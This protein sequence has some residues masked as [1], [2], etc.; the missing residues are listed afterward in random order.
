MLKDGLINTMESKKLMIYKLCFYIVWSLFLFIILQKGYTIIA[1]DT[2]KELREMNMPAF[3]HHLAYGKNL[4]ARSA[5]K[6]AIPAPTSMYGFFVPLILAPFVRLFSFTTLNTLQIC[7]LVTLLIE[8]AGALIFYRLLRRKT[9]RLLL[10]AIGMLLFYSCYWRYSAFGGAFPDQW[11]LTLSILLADILYRDKQKNRLRPALYILILI[12]LFYIKQYFALTA[13][14]L[15]V[16]LFIYSKKDTVKFL[17]YGIVFGILSVL[18]VHLI[19]PLYFSEVLPIAQ[20]QVLTGDPGYSLRQ[21]VVLNK[22]YGGLAVLGFLHILIEIYMMI[23]K[24]TVKR[25]ISYAFCQLIFLLLPVILISENQGTN[26]TYY[27]QLWYPYVILYCASS[28]PAITAYIK[29]IPHKNIRMLC[30][31]LQYALVLLP[32]FKMLPMFRCTLM[33]QEEEAAW[34]RAYDILE[35][36]SEGGLLVSMLLSNYCLENNIAT[37]NYGQAEY[38]TQE[39]LQN[40]KNNKLWRNIFLFD[41]TEEIL[42]KNISYHIQIQENIAEQKYSCIAITYTWEYWLSEEYLSDAGYHILTTES[43]PAGDQRWN[44]TFYVTD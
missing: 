42:Q 5:L 1:Y 40:Y 11:G 10:S 12:I 22:L 34:K 17:L 43:L 35:Q 18:L 21:I 27:L 3:V 7:E 19:F 28:V 33:T 29:S 24:K 23:K 14:G 30:L 39:N 4:Y 38:N 26:Y 2:P 15:F 20:G 25:E 37:S 41:H 6:S 31:T 36:Y 13:V 9:N 44:V 8:I 16:Y 32:L